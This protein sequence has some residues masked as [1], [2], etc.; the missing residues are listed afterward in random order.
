MRLFLDTLT[1]VRMVSKHMIFVS[2]DTF[3]ILLSSLVV[4]LSLLFFLLQYISLVPRHHCLI[5]F[6]ASFH[7]IGKLRV[8]LG[9]LNLLLQP[10]LFI[11]KF[12]KTILKHLS[13]KLFLFHMQLLLKFS[14]AVYASG[15]IHHAGSSQIVQLDVT[16]A[17]VVTH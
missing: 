16:E 9:Y 1:N 6:S 3:D 13:L 12:T 17:E 11:V 8:P 7:L 14:R 10:L 2:V 15:L 4:Y 5:F